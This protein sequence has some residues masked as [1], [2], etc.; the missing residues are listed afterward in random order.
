MASFEIVKANGKTVCHGSDT[1]CI[2]V[3]K[4]SYS[5]RRLIPKDSK[6][7]EVSVHGAGSSQTAY[8]C[9]VCMLKVIESMRKII[10]EVKL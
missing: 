6:S 3:I 4:G 10:E 9:K 1:A 8:Y 2:G 7:L 5:W